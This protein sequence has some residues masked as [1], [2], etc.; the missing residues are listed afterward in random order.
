MQQ[1]QPPYYTPTPAPNPGLWKSPSVSDLTSIYQMSNSHYGVNNSTS[2]PPTVNSS[3][4]GGPFSSNPL[5]NTTGAPNQPPNSLPLLPNTCT[6]EPT[7]AGPG[8]EMYAHSSSHAQSQ[9]Q[10]V[11]TGSPIAT[12]T[13]VQS[14][15]E[16]DRIMAKIEQDNRILAELDKTRSTIGK[17]LLV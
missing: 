2:N 10:Q 15:S 3:I 5:P 8:T 13:G 17:C 12:S 11:R 6:V 7:V 1:Q 4:R 16:I 14:S 9:T